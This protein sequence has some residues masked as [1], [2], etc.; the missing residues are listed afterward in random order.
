MT[1]HSV[2][3]L[4]IIDDHQVFAAS[5]ARVLSDED[6]ISVVASAATV[7]AGLSAM[8]EEV[9]VV[10]MDFRLGS[11]DGVEATRRLVAEWPHVRVVML[12]ASHDESVM[13]AALEA[14]CSGFITKT[15]PLETVLAAVRGAAIGESVVSPAL[16]GRLLP[17]LTSRRGGRNPDLTQRELEVLTLMAQGGSNQAIADQLDIARDTVRNHV[18]S[19]LS[20]LGVNSK[21]QAV[22]AGIQRGLISLTP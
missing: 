15:E 9:D 13:A 22:T 3:R 21:L 1:G 18:A 20:K 5:L 19:I 7:G 11:E 16:L 12:T 2:I 14:G 4:I 6:D 17:R 10:L 8:S